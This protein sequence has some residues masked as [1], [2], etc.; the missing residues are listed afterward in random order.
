[1]S[2]RITAPTSV[3]G[4]VELPESKSFKNRYLTLRYLAGFREFK[5]L[6]GDVHDVQIYQNML[7]SGKK[8]LDCEDAGTALRFGTAL[9]SCAEGE[10][11]LT[12]SKRLC[13]RPLGPLIDALRKI[14]AEITC[15]GKEGFAPLKIR[16]R[17]LKGGKVIVPAGISSQ[18]IS[19][20]LMIGP[21]C[22]EGI[23]IETVGQVVSEPYIK[24][25][26]SLMR[27]IGAKVLQT[28]KGYKTEAGKYTDKKI[29]IEK[30]WSSASFLYQIC[31]LSENSEIEIPGLKR[32]SM[33]GDVSCLEIFRHLGVESKFTDSALRIRNSGQSENNISVDF[34]GNPDLVQPFVMA[35][36]GKNIQLEAK[37]LFNLHLKETDRLKAL[38]YNLDKIGFTFKTSGHNAELKGKLKL[39]VTPEFKSFNDHRM[40]MSLAPLSLVFGSVVTDEIHQVDKSFPAYWNEL[41][42]PGFS[43]E[44]IH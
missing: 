26:I 31:A 1:M 6:A 21:M 13:E 39:N 2:F 30:D 8:E 16:S 22:E 35:C 40:I 23:E 34:S 44:E 32:D 36:A 19:A 41:K 15:Q 7:T 27:E 20:L 29:E 4:I 25:T 3:R 9:F 12:G 33:Q 42:K 14:G 10:R 38:E 17:K 18:F 37:N 24:M 5:A 11:I 28:E 43:V